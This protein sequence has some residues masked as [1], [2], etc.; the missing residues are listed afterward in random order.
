MSNEK[1]NNVKPTEDLESAMKALIAKGKKEGMLRD[2]ELNATLSKLDLTPEKI[3]EIYD[4][5][6]ALGIQI[7]TA[8]LE[9]TTPSIWWTPS[10]TVW[11][12]AAWTTTT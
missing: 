6:E 8:E 7:F 12:W 10:T 4:S 5:F 2:T 1:K 3:D 9:R 11:I